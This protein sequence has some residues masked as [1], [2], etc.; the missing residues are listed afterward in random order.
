MKTKTKQTVWVMTELLYPNTTVWDSVTKALKFLKKQRRQDEA[1]AVIQPL[2]NG[3][4]YK[5]YLVTQTI[6]GEKYTDLITFNKVVI[7]DYG[8]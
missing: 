3:K 5:E 2:Y 8:E 4:S 1:D 7:N 6:L